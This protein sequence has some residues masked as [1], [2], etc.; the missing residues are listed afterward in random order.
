MKPITFTNWYKLLQYK[1]HV[2]EISESFSQCVI[3]NKI[4]NFYLFEIVKLR[5]SL[6]S[7]LKLGVEFLSIINL[8]SLSMSQVYS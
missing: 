6:E 3:T 5:L 1:F 4:W 8:I 2:E 7:Q